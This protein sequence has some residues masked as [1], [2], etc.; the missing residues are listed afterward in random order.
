MHPVIFCPNPLILR[1]LMCK[2]IQNHIYHNISDSDRFWHII[3]HTFGKDYDMFSNN[4]RQALRQTV[5]PKR[6]IAEVG[7][8]KA[9]EVLI[10]KTSPGIE[11]C[12]QSTIEALLYGVD[13][14]KVLVH[15]LDA[16]TTKVV[17]CEEEG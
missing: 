14:R 4:K 11:T 8:L 17:S 13:G 9:G 7:N 1:F 6:I 5:S 16:N 15:S 2:I 10:V 12:A 3:P